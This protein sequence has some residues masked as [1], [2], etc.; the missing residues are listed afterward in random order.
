MSV[1]DMSIKTTVRIASAWG[2]LDA[3]GVGHRVIATAYAT[4]TPNRHEDQ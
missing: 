4:E 3:V 1:T 2:T